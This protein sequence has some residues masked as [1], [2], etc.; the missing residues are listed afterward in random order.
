M[1]RH[2]IVVLGGYG[3]FGGR[4]CR[5]LARHGGAELVV[6][7]R[8][9]ERARDFVVTLRKINREGIFQS[10]RLDHSAPDFER[11]LGS[12][13][14]TIVVHAAGPFQGQDYRVAE[15]CLNHGSHY[16]DLADGR[17]F[18]ADFSRL[19]AAARDRGVLLVAGASTLPGV[20]SAVVNHLASGLP[21]IERIE[22]AILP[23]NR[24]ERGRSTIAAVFS[25]VGKPIRILRNGEWTTG[26]GWLDRRKVDHPTCA[27]W[28]GLCDVPDLALFP[29]H[30][31]TAK[32]VTFH[33]GLELGW[34]Q[35][36]MWL[37]AC[38]ARLGIVSDWS[39]HAGIFGRVS[40]RLISL[41]SDVGGMQLSVTGRD[42][43]GNR[44]RRTWN[45]TAGS[46]HGPEIPCIPA[47]VVA[48]KLVGDELPQ[49]GAMPCMELMSLE[50][51]ASVAAEFDIEW[52]VIEQAG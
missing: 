9:R 17:R 24:T 12:L 45:L 16:V 29:G 20:S 36:G 4:I 11:D 6:A 49:R 42:D 33:A 32:T 34:Q 30:Y 13:A 21:V 1:D 46:N 15:A 5:A 48:M 7:G 25:Y 50:D 27:R 22:T 19:D 44:V 38:V 31:Q 51:F 41:G 3:H 10:A 37:M 39:K 14:P 23:A 47:R 26:Y 43:T 18:V 8:S 52:N 35:W 40:A 2:R 28:A